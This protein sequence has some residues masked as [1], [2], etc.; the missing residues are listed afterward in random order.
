M[1]LKFVGK[2]MFRTRGRAEEPAVSI[3][4]GRQTFG[5]KGNTGLPERPPGPCMAPVP[6]YPALPQVQGPIGI[7]KK[8]VAFPA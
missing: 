5:T 8:R 4:E 7:L 1:R 2:Q 3:L 6:W